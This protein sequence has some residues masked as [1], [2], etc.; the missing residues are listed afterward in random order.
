M[1]GL[2]MSEALLNKANV[3]REEIGDDYGIPYEEALLTKEVG[4]DIKILVK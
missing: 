1:S 4:Q 3:K 2:D